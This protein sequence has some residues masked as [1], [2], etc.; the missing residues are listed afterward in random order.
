VNGGLV[1]EQIAA[2][3]ALVLLEYYDIINI[4]F[5]ASL[6]KVIKKTTGI[7]ELTFVK[8]VLAEKFY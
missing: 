5:F 8:Y 2:K 1:P 7:N 4:L 3:T 6:L